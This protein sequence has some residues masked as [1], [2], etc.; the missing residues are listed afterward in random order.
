MKI[1]YNPEKKE[2]DVLE[3][4]SPD[5]WYIDGY[6]KKILDTIK[7]RVIKKKVRDEVIIIDGGE[8]LGKSTFA[9]QIMHY[10]FPETYSLDNTIYS[11]DDLLGKIRNNIG[12]GI[13][14]DEAYALINKRQ[15]LSIYNRKIIQALTEMGNRHHVLI[16]CLPSFFELDRYPAIH[17]SSI[18]FHIFNRGRNRVGIKVYP[19]NR[20]KTLYLKGQKNYNY[21][22]VCP[23]KI[24]NFSRFFPYNYEEYNKRK[25]EQ[26]RKSYDESIKKEPQISILQDELIKLH[27]K[28][29]D[30]PY[31]AAEIL[32]RNVARVK[33]S[34]QE[35]INR[36]KLPDTNPFGKKKIEEIDK[37]KVIQIKKPKKGGHKPKSEGLPLPNIIPYNSQKE[38]IKKGGDDK[39]EEE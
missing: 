20:K 39:E 32:N 33:T 35:L 18:L 12:I 24:L 37:S 28:G 38:D 5:G 7:K 1:K 16:F 17:R 30:D 23:M 2:F 8:Q 29:I 22:C 19:K 9:H 27:E 11:L 34:M 15:A 31:K 25:L 13:I 21:K 4:G 6:A 26:I 14:L 10:L 3:K 36:G